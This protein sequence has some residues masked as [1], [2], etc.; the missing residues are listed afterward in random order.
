MYIIAQML[1]KLS[2][3]RHLGDCWQFVL[4][5]FHVILPDKDIQQ[6]VFE[7]V[8]RYFFIKVFLLARLGCSSAHTWPFYCFFRCVKKISIV[9]VVS[10][11]FSSFHSIPTR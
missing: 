6:N 9:T 3:I 2:A 10:N 5:Y 7:L 1:V 11:L 8:T 4:M